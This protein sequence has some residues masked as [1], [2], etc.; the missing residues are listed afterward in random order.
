MDIY[1][2]AMEMEKDGETYYRELAEK[3]KTEGTRNILT[4]LANAEVMHYRLFAYMKRHEI[5]PPADLAYLGDIKNIFV[6]MRE[7]KEPMVSNHEQ[8]DL[9]RKVQELEKKTRD[10]YR[11][12]SGEVEE[13]QK[14][15]FLK[16]SE[17][18]QKHYNI[19]ETIIQMV[20]R[21]RTWLENPEWYHLEDY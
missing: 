12:K 8:I 1:E 19:M 14:A 3:A 9:Y 7:N 6:R 15:M 18:E 21:P 5:S 4:R 2:Y 13:S 10:F 20:S 17:E 11:E 16:I